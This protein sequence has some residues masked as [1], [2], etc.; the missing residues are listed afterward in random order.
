MIIGTYFGYTLISTSDGD[1]ETC[2][3]LNWCDGFLEKLSLR[4]VLDGNKNCKLPPM[5]SSNTF[6]VG[7]YCMEVI[8]T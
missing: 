2:N 7:K 8:L 5:I 6:L 3:F 4:N 1:I